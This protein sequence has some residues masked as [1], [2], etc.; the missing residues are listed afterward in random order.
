MALEEASEII[1]N[2]KMKPDE[3][4]ALLVKLFSV[5]SD[6]RVVMGNE[7]ALEMHLVK[8]NM[9]KPDF[10]FN[11]RISFNGELS[12]IHFSAPDKLSQPNLIDAVT[13]VTQ[14]FVTFYSLLQKRRY[15]ADRDG[16]RKPI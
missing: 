10:H 14:A 7:S 4:Y 3:L 9:D 16:D 12:S 13:T 1:A 8:L 2:M 11:I 5:D 15:R 6:I